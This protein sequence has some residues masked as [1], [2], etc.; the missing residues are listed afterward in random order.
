MKLAT[1]ARID[2]LVNV[3]LFEGLTKRQIRAIA[4][5]SNTV[6][7]RDGATVVSE[8]SNAHSLFVIVDGSVDVMRKGRRVTRLGPGEFFGE[9]ALFDPGPRTAT[10]VATSDVVA[11]ELSRK[12]LLDA[13]AG[14]P[15]ICVRMMTTLARRL[16]EATE[17]VTY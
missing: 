1:Q 14:D 4:T 6:R 5:A 7:R 9:I 10:V 16:R 2:H 12:G 17:K 3:P 8:G 11:L 15:L 13:I